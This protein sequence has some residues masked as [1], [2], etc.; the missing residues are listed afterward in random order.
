MRCLLSLRH[1]RKRVGVIHAGGDVGVHHIRSGTHLTHGGVD[2]TR[3]HGGSAHREAA[4]PRLHALNVHLSDGHGGVDVSVIDRKSL[5]MIRSASWR[6]SAVLVI[7]I[8]T[9]HSG[10]QMKRS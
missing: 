6:N 4:R 1:G 8:L 9:V 3:V 2:L 7:R 10:R 5:M